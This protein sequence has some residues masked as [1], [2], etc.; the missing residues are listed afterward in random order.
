MVLERFPS[1]IYLTIVEIR[2]T[3]RPPQ[4]TCGHDTSNELLSHRRRNWVIRDWGT[5]E[6]HRNL[7]GFPLRLKKEFQNRR[8]QSGWLV[9]H[10]CTRIL[11]I[12]FCCQ[13][14]FQCY[15][16]KC[17]RLFFMEQLRKATKVLAVFSRGPFFKTYNCI[18][19]LRL[20]IILSLQI[21]F[22]VFVLFT[23]IFDVYFWSQKSLKNNSSHVLLLFLYQSW[24]Q[25]LPEEELSHLKMPLA[26]WRH[27][28]RSVR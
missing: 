16:T 27:L 19:F 22:W 9:G 10:I 17:N 28:R 5:L 13:T 25:Y 20:V 26:E 15:W 8:A 2:S 6:I 23:P 12:C 24:W 1:W 14:F 21:L 7:V 3:L 18:S 4:K 11:Q